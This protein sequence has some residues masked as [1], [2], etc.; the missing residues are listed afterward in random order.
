MRLTGKNKQVYFI[1][2]RSEFI[3]TD[4]YCKHKHCCPEVTQAAD[5][6]A[7]TQKSAAWRQFWEL[8]SSC[9]V[10]E[11]SRRGRR[12]WEAS[13]T[14]TQ[15]RHSVTVLSQ[16]TLG[17][18]RLK[19]SFWTMRT[20]LLRRKHSR[21]EKCLSFSPPQIRLSK[22]VALLCRPLCLMFQMPNLRGFSD[23]ALPWHA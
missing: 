11:G 10:S 18:W 2:S 13:H 9:S 22:Q 20:R 12:R 7:S 8:G 6:N 19:L 5:G 1:C 21:R 16:V 15:R 4:G 3:G 17:W 23:S 14:E